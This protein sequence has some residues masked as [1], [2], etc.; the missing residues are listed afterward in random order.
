MQNSTQQKVEACAP[1]S[2]LFIPGPTYK[3]KKISIFSLKI[4]V[5]E[6]G[7]LW[8]RLRTFYERSHLQMKENLKFFRSKSERI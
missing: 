6:Y 8:P 2:G 3:W 7:G 5:A 1:A 4:Y